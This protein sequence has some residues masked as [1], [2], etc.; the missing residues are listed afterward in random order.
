MIFIPNKNQIP[1]FNLSEIKRY[2][3]DSKGQMPLSEMLSGCINEAE[4]T[5]EYRL[6]YEEA[7]VK[8]DGTLV[9]GK[10]EVISND[11]R[12]NLYGCD[13]AIVF[14]ATVGVGIDRLIGKYSLI[15]P[16]RAVVLDALGAER[17]EALCD[18][19]CTEVKGKYNSV[20]PRFSCG[21]G[22]FSLTY[23]ENI[24]AFLDCKKIGL[25]LNESLMM[26]PSKSVTAVVGIKN[27]E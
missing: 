12:K 2:L 21:Y 4:N 5:F 13:K 16:S 20:R 14:G 1:D 17:I 27:K 24:F 7:L 15:S 25:T 23:Q 26:S 6:I 3:G 10:I 18:A 8:N 19:F 11:L 22:D 9:L